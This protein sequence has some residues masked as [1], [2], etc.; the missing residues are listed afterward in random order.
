LEEELKERALIF[1]IQRFSIHDGPGIRTTLFFKGC[2]LRCRWCQNPESHKPEREIAF[3][4]ERCVG[5]FTCRAVCPNHAIIESKK[6]RIDYQKCDACGKCVSAC[7]SDALRMVGKEWEAAALLDEILKDRDF[8]EESGGGLTLSGGE[9]AFQ[10]KFLYEFLP[11]AKK[12]NIHI[13]METCGM[14]QWHV[15]MPIFPYIALIY[16]DVKIIDSEKH[17]KLT[18]S[19]NRLIFENFNQ[20]ARTFPNLQPRM[21]VI[22]TVNDDR[23]NIVDTARLLRQNKI[24]SIH[25]LTYHKLGEAKLERIQTNLTPLEISDPAGRPITDVK[26]WFADEGIEAT[27]YE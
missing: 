2:P 17:K 4:R 16:Y 10:S 5:C 25:L 3:Y 11:L 9:P 23:E 19:D 20:L 14:F 8:F 13:T 27:T 12:E 21:P 18:G 26:K 22:P 1:D 24:S 6:T 15:M 7:S